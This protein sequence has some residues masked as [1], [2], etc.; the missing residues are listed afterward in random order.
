MYPV[1]GDEATS[2]INELCDDVVITIPVIFPTIV[3]CHIVT[4]RCAEM[5][6]AAAVSEML[7]GVTADDDDGR[8]STRRGRQEPPPHNRCAEAT[9]SMSIITS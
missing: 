4:R 8:D 1:P 5:A 9:L 2:K 6:A 7:L 3:S